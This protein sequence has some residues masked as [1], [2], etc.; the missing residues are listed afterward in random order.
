MPD[1]CK[2]RRLATRG[3]VRQIAASYGWKLI[4]NHDVDVYICMTDRL[5]PQPPISFLW[6]DDI[7]LVPTATGGWTPGDITPHLANFMFD[8]QLVRGC[9]GRDNG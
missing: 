3:E 6:R 8:M 9:S 1:D 2:Q 7:A 5:V 4:V